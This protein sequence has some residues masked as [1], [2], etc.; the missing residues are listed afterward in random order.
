M[1]VRKVQ[2]KLALIVSVFLLGLGAFVAVGHAVGRTIGFRDDSAARDLHPVGLLQSTQTGI[3]SVIDPFTASQFGITSDSYTNAR[4]LGDTSAGPVY[5]LP[6]STGACVVLLPAYSCGRLSTTSEPVVG[7]F[8][9]NPAGKYLVGGGLVADSVNAVSV[10]T[11]GTSSSVAANLVQGGF[12]VTEDQGIA[13]G[14]VDI[15]VAKTVARKMASFHGPA[16]AQRPT[17]AQ[18]AQATHCTR[19]APSISQDYQCDLYGTIVGS[20]YYQTPSTALRDSNKIN[21]SASRS[22]ALC[23][24]GSFCSYGTGQAGGQTASDGYRAAEC[25]QTGADV[26]GRCRTDWHD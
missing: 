1:E 9:Q 21:M 10:K 17:A 3:E 25:W 14:P 20:G 5:A 15:V 16:A 18:R 22:W 23:Y 4:K 24:V 6:G 2:R 19:Y 11:H 13:S 8:V 7:V 26:S 12:V